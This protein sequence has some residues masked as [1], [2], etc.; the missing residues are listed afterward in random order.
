M[1]YIHGLSTNVSDGYV[2]AGSGYESSWRIRCVVSR[3]CA[4]S[5]SSSESVGMVK[6]VRPSVPET[7]TSVGDSVEGDD[8]GLKVESDYEQCALV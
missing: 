2:L 1:H 8:A 4:T 5:L 7:M 6:L 3:A